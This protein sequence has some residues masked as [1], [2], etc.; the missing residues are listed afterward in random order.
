[1]GGGQTFFAVEVFWLHHL[2]TD[3]NVFV[4]LKKENDLEVKGTE[5]WTNLCFMDRRNMHTNVYA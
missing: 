4:F 3:Y 1:M 2:Y 5:T